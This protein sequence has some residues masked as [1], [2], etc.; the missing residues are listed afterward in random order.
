ML[1][2]TF[3]I[4]LKAAVAT[5]AILA[6]GCGTVKTPSYSSVAEYKGMKTLKIGKGGSRDTVIYKV[7]ANDGPFQLQSPVQKYKLN[8][9][10]LA[11]RNHKGLDLGGRRGDPILAAHPGVVV[12]AGRK[13]RGYG[14]M[15]LIEYNGKWATLYAHLDKYHVQEGQVVVAGERIGDMGATGRATG[16]HLHF[17]LIKNKQ[18]IDPLTYM[19]TDRFLTSE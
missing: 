1:D 4:F 12:Y 13:F 15:V 7:P 14:K 2:P 16:V 17:E 9:G 19:R 11:K 3:R 10:F 5:A 18:P 6:I 8:R